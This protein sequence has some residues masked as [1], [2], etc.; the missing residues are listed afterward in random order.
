MAGISRA[1]ANARLKTMNIKG[2]PYVGVDQRVLAFWDVFPEGAIT[3]E[4]L[5]RTD[6]GCT[7]MA[8][9]YN[10]GVEIATGTA[11]EDKNASPINKTS[12]Y[13]NCETSAVGRA[14]GFA[15]IG[16]DG[17][18]ASAEEVARAIGIQESKKK[19]P[20]PAQ[21]QEG[22]VELAAARSAYDTALRD[23]CRRNNKDK[24]ELLKAQEEHFKQ[25]WTEWSIERLQFMADK[26]PKGGN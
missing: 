10:M 5:E 12:Y 22:L 25:P 9:V 7:C 23:Y 2:K 4:W 19:E 6:E 20:K 18:I 15:G 16:T 8:H 1:E 13:E 3:T 24:A 14:L 11:H 26:F 21:E 17:S